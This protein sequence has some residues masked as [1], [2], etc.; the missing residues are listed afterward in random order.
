MK[1]K[2]LILTI[3]SLFLINLLPADDGSGPIVTPPTPTHYG[4][5]QDRVLR[6]DGDWD[7]NVWTCVQWK[8]KMSDGLN[9]REVFC[10]MIYN[11]GTITFVTGPNAW[12]ETTGQDLTGIT[13]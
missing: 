7:G 13:K 3:L 1:V 8:I 2:N 6:M 12:Q 9:F 4:P 5:W 10:T 11:N